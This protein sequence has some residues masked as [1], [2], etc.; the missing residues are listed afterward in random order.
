MTCHQSY[1]APKPPPSAYGRTAW[2]DSPSPAPT[3]PS[4]SPLLLR[5]ADPRLR[6]PPRNH[7]LRRPRQRVDEIIRRHGPLGG[8][9]AATEQVNSQKGPHA[10]SSPSAYRL[11]RALASGKHWAG[12]A[13][14]GFEVGHLHETVGSSPAMRHQAPNRFNSGRKPMFA[15]PLRRLDR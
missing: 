11:Q 8:R 6:L 3:P 4:P 7:L 14:N 10:N 5:R 2:P 9:H 15:P 13:R 1:P 12:T